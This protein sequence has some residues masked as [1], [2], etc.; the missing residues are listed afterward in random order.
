[1]AGL[2]IPIPALDDAGTDYED[3]KIRIHKWCQVC[4]IPKADQAMAIQVLMS[5]KAIW[6]SKENPRG[7]A[8][9]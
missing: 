5:K 3:Y 4:K 6:N 2:K 9:V 7:G 1:M 8:K